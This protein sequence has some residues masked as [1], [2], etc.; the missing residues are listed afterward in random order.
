VA[1]LDQE[2]PERVDGGGFADAGRTRDADADRLAGVGQQ[3]LHQLA[4]RRLMIAAPAFNQRDRPRQRRAAAGA[5]V[6]GE[7][8]DVDRFVTDHR[9]LRHRTFVILRDFMWPDLEF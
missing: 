7:G 2:H 6:V 1:T 5:E 9:R 8:F 4:R 3:R